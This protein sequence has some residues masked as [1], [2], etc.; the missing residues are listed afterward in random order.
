MSRWHLP[1][2]SLVMKKADGIVPL[3]LVLAEEGKNGLPGPAPSPFIDAGAVEGLT[4]RC[5]ARHCSARRPRSKAAAPATTIA[6]AIATRT[7]R[8]MNGVAACGALRHHHTISIAAPA[9]DA[10][11]C[12]STSRRCGVV[13]PTN[14]TAI[15][16]ARPAADS[17]RPVQLTARALD[18]D[19]PPRHSAAARATPRRGCR[20]T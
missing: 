2:L 17:A 18:R 5:A 20:A 1:Q 7:A 4:M 14:R 6:T 16:S 15:P 3:T 10:A 13:A 12:A 19:P 8:A 11:T 9:A